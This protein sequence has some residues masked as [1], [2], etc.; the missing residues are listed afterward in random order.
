MND[1]YSYDQQDFSLEKL[2]CSYGDGSVVCLDITGRLFAAGSFEVVLLCLDSDGYMIYG[3][4]DDGSIR[5]WILEGGHVREI[6][7]YLRAHDT[8]VTAICVDK[9]RQFLASGASDGTL[10]IWKI[11]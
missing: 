5:V 3:G 8:K 6:H 4:C 7:R 9:Q 2:F 1:F 10:K 11:T